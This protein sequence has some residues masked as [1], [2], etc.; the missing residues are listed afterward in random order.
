MRA[1]SGISGLGALA[2]RQGPLIYKPALWLDA[3]EPSTLIEDGAAYFDASKTEYLTVARN[4]SLYLNTP[5]FL[6]VWMN[7]GTP[8]TGFTYAFGDTS[9]AGGT[10]HSLEFTQH[11]GM[12]NVSLRIGDGTTQTQITLPVG[13]TWTANVWH[14]CMFWYDGTTLNWKINNNQIR[15]VNAPTSITTSGSNWSFGRAGSFNNQYWN[16]TLDSICFGKPTAEWILNNIGALTTY[17]YNNGNGRRSTEFKTSL[18]YTGGNPS[19]A[20]SWWDF[21]ER[22]GTRYDSIGTNHL[23]DPKGVGYAAGISGNAAS[24]TGSNN[25]SITSNT[26]HTG[27]V[28]WWA[29]VMFYPTVVD[30]NVRNILGTFSSTAAGGGDFI[31]SFRSDFGRVNIWNG[32][33]VVSY[34]QAALVPTLNAW[35]FWFAYSDRTNVYLAANGGS[36]ISIGSS[37]GATSSTAPF[38][39]G[40]TP[41]NGSYFQGRIC[42]ASFGKPSAGWISSNATALRDYL[43]NGGTP[44]TANDFRAGAYSSSSGVVSYWDLDETSSIRLDRVGTN[45]LSD[46]GVD[47]VG[48]ISAGS[49]QVDGDQVKQWLDKSGNKRN[50]SA[51]TDSRRPTYKTNRLNSKSALLF[52]G[53]DDSLKIATDIGLSGKQGATAIWISR[54]AKTQSTI[55]STVSNLYDFHYRGKVSNTAYAGV[56]GGASSYGQITDTYPGTWQLT[57]LLYDLTLTNKLAVYKNGVLAPFLSFT[58]ELASV[59]PTVTGLTVGSSADQT[60]SFLGGDLAELM[61]FPST[62]NNAQR[63]RMEQYLVTKWM[64]PPVITATVSSTTQLLEWVSYIATNYD[65]YYRQTNTTEWTFVENTSLTY[66]IISGLTAGVSYDFRIDAN[67][68]V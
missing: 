53:V 48:G 49:V 54:E 4:S 62:L 64:S 28:D 22:G 65:V 60:T 18:F 15:T 24:F 35:N 10:T 26:V 6:S 39:I 9:S 32:T 19:G 51:T 21:D 34:S 16:G 50:L 17:L 55:F 12:T 30:G 47:L 7:P 41:G 68:S 59:I 42:F 61:I 8:V 3:S 44:V 46:G 20:I 58:G 45:H 11:S 1:N 31:L 56:A 66:S 52:D 13:S 33:G 38:Y 27:N 14:H 29:A 23:T 43:Y 36:F 67:W 40:G 5:W 2:S 57:S 37:V 25:L 63:Q